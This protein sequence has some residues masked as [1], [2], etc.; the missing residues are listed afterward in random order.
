MGVSQTT[1]TDE[2]FSQKKAHQYKLSILIGVDS[3]LYM[4]FDKDK[5][6][7]LLKDHAFDHPPSATRLPG[8]NILQYVEQDRLLKLPYSA[9]K[10]AYL[11]S[12]QTF[13]PNRLYHPDQKHIYLDHIAEVKN[14]CVVRS[15]DLSLL[16][17]QNV[18]TVDK[19]VLNLMQQLFV[20]AKHFHLSSALY[21][22]YR[23][24]C[25]LSPNNLFLNVRDHHAQFFLFEHQKLIFS[26]QFSI[27]SSDDL[28]YFTLLVYQQHHLST[29]Q[30]SIKVSGDFEEGGDH[31]RALSRYIKLI[32]PVASNIAYQSRESNQ[33][34]L[35]QHRFFDLQS[36]EMCA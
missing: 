11:S 7:L 23:Q 9:V 6:V 36:I 34:Q 12:T 25:D 20:R 19:A 18:Y 15:D 8:T 31:H 13:V 3:F 21:L 22:G 27:S 26:N 16:R 28:V 10:I 29:T 14:D 2:L 4:V 35:N 1:I 33:A 30:Q 32:Y 5:Y 17:A 24:C